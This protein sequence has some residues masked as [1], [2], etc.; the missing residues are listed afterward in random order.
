MFWWWSAEPWVAV[1]WS[2]QSCG[3]SYRATCF[4]FFPSLWPSTFS[5]SSSPS[6]S[7]SHEPGNFHHL[8]SWSF[9]FL[10]RFADITSTPPPHHPSLLSLHYVIMIIA[11]RSLRKLNCLFCSASFLAGGGGSKRNFQPPPTPPPPPSPPVS[12]NSL[13]ALKS[14]ADALTTD[15]VSLI[16]ACVRLWSFPQIF[17]ATATNLDAAHKME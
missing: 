5:S 13:Q 14:A 6:R 3:A 7:S 17:T 11:R 16:A 1:E 8:Q 12:Q 4:V 2:C 9:S 15:H 10:R